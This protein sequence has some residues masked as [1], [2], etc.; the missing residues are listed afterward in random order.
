RFARPLHGFTLVELLVVIVIIGIL[1][2]LLLPAIQSAREGA[3]R[4][5]CTSRLRQIG[6]GL[7]SYHTM[8]SKFPVGCVDR[9]HRRIAWSVYL[10]PHIDRRDVWRA[11]DDRYGSSSEENRQAT[12]IVISTYLCPSTSTYT[13]E[14]NGPTAG[15]KNG[16]GRY[17]AGDQMAYTDYGGMFGDGRPGAA[18]GGG[19]LIR[20]RAVA[21]GDVLD[22]AANTIIVAEDTGRG[23][24]S[25]GQWANGENIFDVLW[26]INRFQQDEM[27]SDHP[28]GAQALFVDGS[29]RFLDESMPLPEL[30]RLCTRAGGDAPSP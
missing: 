22:G 16:N 24:V 12:S 27:Y 29:V 6:V 25:D 7:Q 8:R 2:A 3:R 18:I 10:L 17:D 19:V 11:F 5:Q 15:D 30:A 4:T 21:L 1:L 9:T 13:W 14:R 26:P 28:G 20:E 23:W